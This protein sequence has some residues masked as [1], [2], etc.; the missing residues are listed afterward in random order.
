[1]SVLLALG[2]AFSYGLADFVGGLTSRTVSPW[3]V[4]FV[5]QLGSGL[6]MVIVALMLPGEPIATDLWW[7]VAAGVAN[8]LGTGFLYRGLSSGRMGVVEPIS[9]VGTALVPVVAGV[10]FGERLSPLMW[11]GIL[12]AIPGIW[13]ASRAAGSAWTGGGGRPTAGVSDGALAGLGFGLLFVAITRIGDDA[14]LLPL[15]LNQLVAAG[16][17]VLLATMMH[18]DWIP[19]D[20][21]VAFGVVSG[22]LMALATLGIIVASQSGYLSVTAV[23]AA[24]YPAFT[25]LLA[26]SVIREKIYPAQAVGLALGATGVVCVVLG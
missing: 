1:M 14:G 15:A 18:G 12:V 8:G 4:A 25:V 9:G 20:P 5:A 23:I 2:A 3:A 13:L 11:L 16:A 19:R 7:A 22:V 17:I 26:A 21:R 6:V 24:L 10:A